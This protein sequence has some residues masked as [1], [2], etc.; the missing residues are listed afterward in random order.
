VIFVNSAD[1]DDLKGIDPDNLRQ[2][3]LSRDV[4]A[5]MLV[6]IKGKIS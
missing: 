5:A 3:F 4:T 6:Q 1:I 2:M